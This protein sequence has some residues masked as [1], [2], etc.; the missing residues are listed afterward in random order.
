MEGKWNQIKGRFKEKFGEWFNDDDSV[1]EGQFD[2]VI[3]KI[4]E[5]SGKT[6]A[7]IEKLIENWKE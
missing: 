5:R 1:I 7:E 2:Q 6:K 3:G 4:Q